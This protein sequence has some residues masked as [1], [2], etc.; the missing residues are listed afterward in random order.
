MQRDEQE[1]LKKTSREEL[2][3]APR[4]TTDFNL[5]RNLRRRNNFCHVPVSMMGGQGVTIEEGRVGMPR[6]CDER[7]GCGRVRRQPQ[8]QNNKK[9]S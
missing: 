8:H 6:S 4:L 7:S 3:R 5:V 2:A 9:R 1:F